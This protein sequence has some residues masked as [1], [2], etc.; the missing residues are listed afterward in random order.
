VEKEIAQLKISW[1]V[2][3]KKIVRLYFAPASAAL[4]GV[5]NPGHIANLTILS[6]AQR[7]KKMIRRNR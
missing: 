5:I 6:A 3:R 4:Q 1:I 7:E 2:Y